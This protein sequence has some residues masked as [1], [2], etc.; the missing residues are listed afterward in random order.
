MPFKYSPFPLGSVKTTGWLQDQLQLCANG[1]GGHLFDFYDYV[2]K[3][4]WVGGECEYSELNESAPY[5]FNAIVPLAW[6]LDDAR[7]KEQA[8]QFLDYVL[9]HQAEDGWLGPET[10]RRTRGIWAR[11]LLFFGLTVIIR[12]AFRPF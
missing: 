3:S 11:S 4:T 10:T 8:K 9:D 12:H 7:L 1:L 2:A 5:W 6:T